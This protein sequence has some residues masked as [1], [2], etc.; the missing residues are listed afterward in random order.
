MEIAGKVAVVTGAGSGIGRATSL[1]L[2]S[3]GASVIVAD[4][5]EDGGRET[6]RQIDANGGHASFI[7][8]DV[9]VA[10]DVQAMIAEALS[11]F[12]GADVLVNNAGV[13]EGS[14]APLGSFPHIPA[15]QWLR[16]LDINLRGVILATQ[17]AIDAMRGRGGAI[18]NIASGGGIGFGPH[19]SPVY[20]ASKAAVARFSA[21]LAPLYERMQVRVNCVCPGWVDTPMSQRTRRELPPEEWAKIA[22][23]AMS[24]PEE[25]ADAVVMLVRDD[26]LAGRIML[27]YEGAPWRLLPLDQ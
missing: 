25:I 19:P 1:R 3:E 4:V 6:V 23:P 12:G 5:S 18:V 24:P 10:T 21:A 26:T 17:H 22:P 16:V 2:A 13:V 20:A 15:E 11:S 8:T 7:R 14:L 9:A 27:C